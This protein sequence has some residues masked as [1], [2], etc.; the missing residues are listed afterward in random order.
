LANTDKSC[1]RQKLLHVD[2][3]RQLSHFA[4]ESCVRVE[5][6]SDTRPVNA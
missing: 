4:I 2:S 6:E 3:E 1:T 5:V